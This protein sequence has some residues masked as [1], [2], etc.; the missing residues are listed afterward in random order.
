VE[1][2]VAPERIVATKY[3]DDDPA[4]GIARQMPLCPWPKQAAWDGRGD[5]DQAASY[6]CR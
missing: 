6:A 5:P 4:K 3:V 2:G 1:E